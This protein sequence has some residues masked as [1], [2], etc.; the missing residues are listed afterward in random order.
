MSRTTVYSKSGCVQCTATYRRL[1]RA[2]VDYDTV[3]VTTD[4]AAIE[5]IKSLGH[6]SLPVVEVGDKH[7]AGYRPDLID[8]LVAPESSAETAD[9]PEADDAPNVEVG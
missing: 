8:A 3:D 7:W 9:W 6:R 2:G 1:E 5:Y 4:P